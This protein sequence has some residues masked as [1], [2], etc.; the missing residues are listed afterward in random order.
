[1]QAAEQ[2]QDI[3][4]TYPEGHREYL[5][6]V[7]QEA[8]E[9][10]G[11]LSPE[12]MIDIGRH[13]RIPASKVYGVATFYNQ[14]HFEPRGKCH[15]QVC[16]GTACHVKGSAQVLESISRMLKLEPGHT[17]RDGSFSLEVVSCVGA[18]GLAPVVTVNGEFHAGV[19][20]ESI[21]KLVR[22]Q[23]RIMGAGGEHA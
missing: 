8:Q 9:R 1:M 16:R 21:Q 7:L 12:T 18:C 2:L 22:E 10:L 5:I 23:K 20:P 15:C 13:L 11:Y 14:F 19:T 6:P 17:T 3:Y 4:R